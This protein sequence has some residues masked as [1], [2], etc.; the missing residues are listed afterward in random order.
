MATF[1]AHKNFAVTQVVT[2]PSPA[3]S[4]T[5]LTVTSGGGALLPAAPFNCVVYPTLTYPL[6]TNAEIV[7]VTSVVGDTLTIVR[8]QESSSARSILAGDTIGNVT[9]VKVFTDIESAI[10][11]LP[12]SAIQSVSAGTAVATSP[13]VVFSN[14]NNV[15]FGLNGSVITASVAGGGGVAIS[16]GANSSSTG[17]IVFSNSNGI[18]FGMSTNGVV[19]AS[20]DGIT[21][22]SVQTQSNVQGISAGTQIDRTGD[23]VFSNANGVSFGLNGSVLTASVGGGLAPGS[24]SAGTSSIELGQIVFSNSNNVTFGLNGSTLT[25]SISAAGARILSSYENLP[26]FASTANLP[27]STGHVSH[28]VAFELANN[29][30]ASFI[31]FPANMFGFGT[32]VATIA[33]ASA[34]ASNAIFSTFNAVIYSLGT[35]ANSRSLQFLESG[36]CGFTFSQAVSITNTTQGSYSQGYSANANGQGTTLTTQY[37]LSQSNYFF[38]SNSIVSLFT[39]NRMIDIPFAKSLPAGNYWAVIGMSS[40]TSSGG[41]AGLSGMT[42]CYVRYTN[43]FVAAQFTGSMGI[44]GSTNLSS[45]G[46]FGAGSFSTA[47]GGTTASIPMSAISSLVS[48]AKMYFQMLRSA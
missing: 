48:N 21:S 40:S 31:R 16:A 2:P 32:T 34:T 37:S 28:A 43:H 6:S 1:D 25:A 23:I 7:R 18:T 26:L 5:S 10:N 13:M 14:S 44:M 8:A 9:S 24:V 36:S 17:T 47:G 27:F 46:L 22:Q 29:L 3:N 15:S 38:S 42:G 19:T 20:H 39:G 35:G 45:G 41:A 30:S 11:A 12:Q 4:G 33:S